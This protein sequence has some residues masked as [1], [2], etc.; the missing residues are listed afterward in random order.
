FTHIK[1]FSWA[2]GE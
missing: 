2:V 1:H